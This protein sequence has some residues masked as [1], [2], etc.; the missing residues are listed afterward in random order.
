MIIFCALIGFTLSERV[1]QHCKDLKKIIRML[2]E[3]EIMIRYNA[4]TLKELILHFYNCSDLKDVDFI[5]VDIDDY[6][7][8]ENISQLI[9]H[10]KFELTSDEKNNLQTFFYELGSTDLDGQ[11][12]IIKHYK[13]YYNNNFKRLAEDSGTKCR[14]YNS[15]GILGGAFLAVILI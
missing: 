5:Q 13:D 8:K 7:I 6:E 9:E 14:L 15:I 1:R 2:E 11:I 3:T 4:C 12:A 10:T